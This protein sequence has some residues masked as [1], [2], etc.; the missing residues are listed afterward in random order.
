[1]ADLEDRR[2]MVTVH[3]HAPH[4]QL[5]CKKKPPEGGFF[6]LLS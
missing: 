5:Q 1:M 3:C 4:V 2:Q 6:L